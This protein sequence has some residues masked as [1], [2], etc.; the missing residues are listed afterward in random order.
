M[1]IFV[2]ILLV[3]ITFFCAAQ[4]KCLIM[5]NKSDQKQYVL[6]E[7]HWVKITYHNEQVFRGILHIDNDSVV[8]IGKLKLFLKGIK[9]IETKRF[10][11]NMYRALVITTAV[12]IYIT[13]SVF[14]VAY[15]VALVASIIFIDQ[16]DPR[17]P[18][19]EGLK[20]LD[21]ITDW[22]NGMFRVEKYLE[23]DFPRENFTYKVSAVPSPVKD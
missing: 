9:R 14:V 17:I 12:F 10:G 20:G 22:V 23:L 4:K 2:S 16:S 7:G 19:S 3:L 21:F 11:A 1:R 15:L 8:S 13:A 5:E 18:S 6:E